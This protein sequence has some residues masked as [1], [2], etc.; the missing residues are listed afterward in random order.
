MISI[1]GRVIGPG[2]PPFVVAEL[3]G[4]HNGSLERALAIVDAVAEAG[5]HALKLQ[6][7]TPDTL[8][9]DCDAPS[10]RVGDGHELWGGESLYQLFERAH[11]PWAWH[12]PI[13]ERARERGLVPFSAPF[14]PTAVE[15]LEK[16]DAPAY[17]IAS[18][19]IVDL[20]LIRLAAGTGKP[21]IISTGMASV[22]EIEA[23]VS[24]AR[25]AGCTQL[26]VLSC[27][28][29]YP[30]APSES[31]LR[32]LPLL[33]AITGEVVGLSDHTPGIGAALA[34]V[35]LGACLIEKHVTLSRADG[36]VDSAF[37]LEPAEL[38]AL[39]AE[40]ERAWQSL[41]EPVL[42]PRPSEREGLRFRR[43]LYVVR[44]VSA[45]E[46][47]TPENVRSIRPAGGLPP[48]AATAVM[49]RRFTRDAPF[50]TPLT[51]DLI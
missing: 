35:A 7:Y 41:G 34:A 29:S 39:V 4:N 28:A 18:S 51:W 30:A 1:G 16:L 6:T 20:P 10:F 15:L 13:F 50:G 26:A 3:S 24:A 11:T 9:I 31:N 33:A 38:A 19:E 21:L 22:A 27:T 8:T 25:A 2:Q 12:E 43:S 48:D 36:G 49:G 14:D 17:K 37:S 40:S 5:A 45:G 32:A 47:V 23:A 44:D 46:P 42:G